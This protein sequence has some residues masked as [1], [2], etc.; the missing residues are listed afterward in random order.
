MDK[1]TVVHPQW[2]IVLHYIVMSYQAMKRHR[3]TLM[4]IIKVKEANLRRLHTVGVQLYDI[5]EKA[6]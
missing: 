2:N 5:L 4:Y 1:E 3:G 6:N